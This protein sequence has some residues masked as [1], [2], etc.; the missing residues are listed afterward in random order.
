M[1]RPSLYIAL[2]LIAPLMPRLAYGASVPFTVNTSEPVTVT[3]TGGTP[4]LQLDVGGTT[5]YAGYTSGSGSAALTFTYNTQAGDVDLD[6]IAVASPLQ[7][8]GGAITDAAGNTLSPLTFS[9]PVTSGVRIDHPSLMMDFA[10]DADGTFLLNGTTYGSFSAFLTA[11][12]GT[13]TRATTAS[14]FDSTGTLQIAASG[15][16]RFDYNPVSHAARG[17]LIE[18]A[19]TNIVPSSEALNTWSQLGGTPSAVADTTVAP[20]GATTGD[21]LTNSH[22]STNAYFYAALSTTAPAS[23]YVTYS[24][25]V[26]T[27]SGSAPTIGWGGASGTTGGIPACTSVGNGWQR[28]VITGATGSV[29]ASAWPQIL[30]PP[31]SSIAAWGAQIEVG[32]R[33]PTSYIRTTGS[34][35]SR[36]A[37]VINLSPAGWLGSGDETITAEGDVVLNQSSWISVFVHGIAYTGN[38]Y[39]LLTASGQATAGYGGANLITPNIATSNTAFK[40]AATFGAAATLSAL[41]G[42]VQTGPAYGRNPSV[43]TIC[44]GC[45]SSLSLNG[46]LRRLKYYPAAVSSSQIQLMTQ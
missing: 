46:H 23:T 2:A 27:L 34:A 9:V 11:A 24:V 19:R 32:G 39:L 16:P 25:F 8:N 40:S 26:K 20:D 5:R 13:Y 38:R 45:G 4:R 12:G 14:Y 18:E 28:C 1:P 7:L 15:V 30:V 43:T 22:V 6:G 41:N 17:L 35:A 37:D 33:Y 36:N 42:T 21:T 3:T 31:S 44:I 29:N 10:A